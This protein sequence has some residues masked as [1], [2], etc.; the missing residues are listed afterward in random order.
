ME[1]GL[2]IIQRRVRTLTTK[3][4]DD[5][6]V[7]NRIPEWDCRCGD[8]DDPIEEKPSTWGWLSDRLVAVDYALP[9]LPEK[10]RD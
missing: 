9:V 1:D 4:F 7:A 3:E 2:I 10:H 8:G 5:E 6:W